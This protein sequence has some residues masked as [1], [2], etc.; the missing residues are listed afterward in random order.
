M[1][2]A[3]ISAQKDGHHGYQRRRTGIKTEIEGF[4]Q[5]CIEEYTH[6]KI[7]FVER[8]CGQP[9]RIQKA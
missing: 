9:M 7:E 3:W 8:F 5:A 4:V 2:A 1:H 6:V